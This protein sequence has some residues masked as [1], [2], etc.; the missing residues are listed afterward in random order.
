MRVRLGAL[1][2][3]ATASLVSVWLMCELVFRLG[4]DTSLVTSLFVFSAVLGLTAVLQELRP[5]APSASKPQNA[6]LPSA[7]I[8]DKVTFVVDDIGLE[9]SSGRGAAGRQ[10]PRRIQWSAVTAMTFGITPHDP[11][12]AL[13]AST[14]AGR[15]HVTDARVLSRKEW[16]LL[17][18]M[19]AESTGRRLML[20]MQGLQKPGSLGPDW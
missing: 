12:I 1:A 9:I 20:D 7:I 17:S 13:Y 5:S 8:T 18:T 10:P 14:S 19:I 4:A 15:E 2:A 6:P 16:E 11:I 3:I